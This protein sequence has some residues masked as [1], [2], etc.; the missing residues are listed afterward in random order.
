MQGEKKRVVYLLIRT[1]L[2]IPRVYYEQTFIVPLMYYVPARY[3]LTIDY[4]HSLRAIQNEQD[5][6]NI[7]CICI[8]RLQLYCIYYIFFNKVSEISSVIFL[9]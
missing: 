9:K 5:D 1:N 8:D 3:I 4:I 6:F 7:A 2:L